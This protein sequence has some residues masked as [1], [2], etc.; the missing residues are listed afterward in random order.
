MIEQFADYSQK[1]VIEHWVVDVQTQT[2]EKLDIPLRLA[3]FAD[4]VRLDDD[5]FGILANTSEGSCIHLYDAATGAGQQGLEYVG[6]D[7]I[8]TITTIP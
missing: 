6:I 5:R 4:P 8:R 1:A 2:A 7:F 3:P